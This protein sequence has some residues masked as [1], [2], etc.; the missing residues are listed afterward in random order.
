MLGTFSER[1]PW[2]LDEK[3]RADQQS[4]CVQWQDRPDTSE[5]VGKD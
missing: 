5:D 1:I 3:L 4:N 2:P